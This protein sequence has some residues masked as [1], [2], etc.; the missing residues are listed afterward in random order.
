MYGVLEGESEKW[1][2]TL[3]YLGVRCARRAAAGQAMDD[4]T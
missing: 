3:H 4:G 1:N 2:L